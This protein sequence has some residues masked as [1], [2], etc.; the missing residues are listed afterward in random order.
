MSITLERPATLPDVVAELNY[1]APT[2]GRPRTYTFEPPPG[3]PRST[4]RP[5]PH[6]V[7]IHNAR[8]IAGEVG[9]DTTGFGLIEHRTAVTDF[10]DEAQIRD[11]YYPESIE[12]IKRATGASRVFIFDHTLRHRIPG[13]E[14]YRDGPRQPATR[15]HVDHTE[16]SGPQRVRDLLPD[17]AE[18]LLKGRVQVINLWRPINHPA[19][20]HPLAFADARSF[21]FADYV[22]S[23]LVYP[24]RVGETYNVRYNPEHRWYYVPQLRT[25]EAL[26]IKCYDSK[27]DGRARFVAHTAFDDPTT[28]PD[29]PP[30]ESIELR[31]LVFHP[32]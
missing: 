6:R 1:L 22:P 25:D 16:T 32:E 2:A 9:L 23:D 13:Q 3:E 4:V 10:G 26:L 20:D 19:V 30:R 27:T 29:A 15:V 24:H 14:D 17:E 11:I 31:T 12:L 8:R 21:P 18:T 7:T 28:P 5:E